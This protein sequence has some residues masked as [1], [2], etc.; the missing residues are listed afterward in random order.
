MSFRIKGFSNIVH[1]PNSK[2]LE[3]KKH[4]IS[5]TGSVSILRWGEAPTLLGPLKRTNLNPKTL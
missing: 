5:E 2:E 4:D 3:D 1:H